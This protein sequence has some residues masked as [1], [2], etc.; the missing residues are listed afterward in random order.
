MSTVQIVGIAV[1]VAIVLLL[2]IA[3]LVTRRRGAAER[4]EPP[5]TA[6]HASFLDE[7]PQ[8]TLAALGKAE[9]P[10]ED[11][12]ID[13]RAPRHAAAPAAETAAVA[14]AAAG[15]GHG[16]DAL[17]LD[18]GPSSDTHRG[19]G[20]I[21]M[22]PAAGMA[23]PAD[24]VTTGE[25]PAAA[26]APDWD[27]PRRSDATQGSAF[28]DTR[29]PERPAEEPAAARDAAGGPGAP[30]PGVPLSDIIVTTSNKMVDLHDPEVRRM[31]TD[32]VKFEI[33]QATQ[34]RLL[35]QNIDAVLQL[36]EAEKIS[37]AL[38]MPE[39]AAAIRTMIKELEGLG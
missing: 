21:A 37:S 34:Y 32:L 5:A 20:L 38:E 17:G 30:G 16:P 33:D 7:A 2:L 6:A 11:I 29:E 3:L 35:G 36:T 15:I 25:L 18:W 10:M 27:E 1:A 22:G 39:S 14:A 24:D 19:D 4:K 23:A 12:T 8:D 26:D 13:P 31:L 9:Q 28:T